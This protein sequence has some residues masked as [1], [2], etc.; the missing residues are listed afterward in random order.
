MAF[1]KCF[2]ICIALFI[3]VNFG[4]AVLVSA[5]VGSIG[6]FFF[7]LSN[8]SNLTR[9]LFGPIASD[10]G[11]VWLGLVNSFSS[12]L[13]LATILTLVGYIVAPLLASLI[14]GY[15]GANKGESFG[16]WFLTA[17]ICMVVFLILSPSNL[18]NTI[19]FGIVNGFLYGCFALLSQSGVIY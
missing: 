1:G 9:A 14:E 10:P 11:I 13:D 15:Y 3:G 6:S 17:C 16:A 18:A 12:G 4:F 5:I 19:I 7:S 2:G 8:M